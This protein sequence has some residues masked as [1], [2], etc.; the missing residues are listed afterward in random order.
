MSYEPGVRLDDPKV[1][2][3]PQDRRNAIGHLLLKVL[4]LELFHWKSVQTD[5]H[6]GNYLVQLK[7]DGFETDRIVL[8]DF[9]ALRKLP[10]TYIHPLKKMAVSSLEGNKDGVVQGA[11]DLTYLDE[12]DSQA[13]KDL[14][15]AI[16][17]KGLEPFAQRYSS[18][19]ETDKGYDWSSSQI[20]QD[21][22]QLAK[23]AVLTTKPMQ[24]PK[25]AVFV[26][27]KLVGTFTLL[28]T[29]EVKYGPHDL[30][31]EMLGLFDCL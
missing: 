11:I 4:F 30:A 29:L 8:L 3:L 17:N 2:K 18:K 20:V 10:N 6:I 15:T 16:V 21:F 14:F 26:D 28:K 1:L 13:R 5:S 7:E 12:N 31:K 24:P 19:P 22:V 23:Q 9:G 25:E 27:R